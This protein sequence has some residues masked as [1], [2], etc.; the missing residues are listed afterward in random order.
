MITRKPKKDTLVAKLVWDIMILNLSKYFV[1][2]LFITLQQK[3]LLC[4]LKI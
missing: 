3:S 2:L 1:Q 4:N